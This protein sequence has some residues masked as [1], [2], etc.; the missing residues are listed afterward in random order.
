[1][2]INRRF[3][4]KITNNAGQFVQPNKPGGAKLPPAGVS[5]NVFSDM[6]NAAGAP[7]EEKAVAIHNRKPLA[8]LSLPTVE[9]LTT[10]IE[11]MSI[12]MDE[13]SIIDID[14]YDRDDPQF[15]TEYVQDIFSFLKQRENEQ[16]LGDY[17]ATVQLEVTVH[18]RNILASL[19][20]QIAYR[21]RLLSETLMLAVRI[22]DRVLSTRPVSA[23]K[24]QLVGAGALIIACKFE[25]MHAPPISDFVYV[26]KEQYTV[27]EMLRIERVLLNTLGFNLCMPSPLLFLRRYSKAAGSDSTTHTLAKYLTELSCLDYG[28]LKYTDSTIAAAAVF[29]ARRMRRIVPFWDR[30]LEYYTEYE[31]R[32]FIDCAAEL[33]AVFFRESSAANGALYT[34]YS[35]KR[36]LCVAQT[37]YLPL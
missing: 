8:T 37:P 9:Q 34:K 16:Q 17:I 6:K 14:E 19:M 1:M 31:E 20:T 30:C 18:H 4:T 29:L 7:A 15:V 36:L 11:S 26:L 5:L 22:V 33:N 13:E 24:L 12:E 23:K 3:G 28:M 10:E 2:F 27:S 35:D 25:E 32:D 21:L